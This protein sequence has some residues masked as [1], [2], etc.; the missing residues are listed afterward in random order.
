MVEVTNHKPAAEPEFAKAK[1]GLVAD[2]RI[3]KLRGFYADWYNP[4][5]IEKRTGWQSK[6]PTF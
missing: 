1:T 2:M 5:Q 3:Q 4:E 6:E